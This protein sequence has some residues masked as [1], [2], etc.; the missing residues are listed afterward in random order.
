[1]W[2]FKFYQV[3]KIEVTL[4]TITSDHRPDFAW[5]GV[6]PFVAETLVVHRQLL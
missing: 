2:F 3:G 6:K 5:L 1:M 4:G